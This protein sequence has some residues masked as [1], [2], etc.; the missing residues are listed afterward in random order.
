ML[1]YST[2][3]ARALTHST[4]LTALSLTSIVWLTQALR[5]MDF[6][7]NQGVPINIFLLLTLLVLPSLLMMV[8]PVALFCA[9]LF[10]YHKLR[11]DSE[12]TV[13]EAAGLSLWK[14]TRPALHVA[15]GVAIVGYVVS[16]YVMP[17]C[18]AKFREMQLFLRNNYV[19]ILL[20]EG[21]FNSP[22]DGLTVF[23]RARAD[24]G[25]FHGILVH[26]NRREDAAV[27][28]MAESGKLS[29][30][31]NGQRF[32]LTNGNRQEM[33]DGKLS[34]LNFD[35]YALDLSF[36]SEDMGTKS[37][38]PREMYIS[39]LSATEGLT[40][41]EIAKRRGELHQRLLWPAFAVTFTLVAL[42]VLLSGEFN[43]RGNAKRIVLAVTLV[44]A[45]ALTGVGLRSLMGN[46]VAYVVIA[47]A[48]V[49]LPALISLWWLAGRSH[50]TRQPPLFP[51]A[52]GH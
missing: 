37:A 10:V 29:Q 6:I 25:A 28:M 33:R 39:D 43:R 13:M 31:A 20:Q 48:N 1:R 4:L 40:P 19:S 22:V 46:H 38:D 16:L 2:Y 34:L 7:V 42:A 32:L 41:E 11:Q 45:I 49:I 15:C 50:A 23:V 47:Y 18:Y 12:L 26:D 21:V 36:Y 14:L 9:V 5:L 8:L 51:A 35:S 3:I 24:D 30:G 27:T 17:L 52:G 44:A